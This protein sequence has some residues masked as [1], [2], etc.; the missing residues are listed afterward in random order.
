MEH[1]IAVL[2][3]LHDL[4]RRVADALLE[5]L[6]KPTRGDPNKFSLEA[7]KEM[8]GLAVLIH[9]TFNVELPENYQRLPTVYQQVATG[10]ARAVGLPD[11]VIRFRED[12]ALTFLKKLCMDLQ[13]LSDGKQNHRDDI[14]RIFRICQ[15]LI[16]ECRMACV[17]PETEE[18]VMDEVD[19]GA[20]IRVG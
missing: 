10:L 4:T 2:W 3:Q 1:R 18:I 12:D 19:I 9:G 7:K 15:A 13:A 14:K 8:R 6:K 5:G 17:V 20:V 16:G 11:G